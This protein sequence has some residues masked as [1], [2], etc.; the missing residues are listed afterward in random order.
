M[1]QK[2]DLLK[3]N[4]NLQLLLKMIGNKWARQQSNTKGDE[5][6]FSTSINLIDFEIISLIGKG[7]FSKVYLVQKKDTKEYFAMKELKKI[8]LINE[9]K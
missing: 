2:N 8:S 9:R 6:F 1:A 7:S 5:E 4:P 3:K